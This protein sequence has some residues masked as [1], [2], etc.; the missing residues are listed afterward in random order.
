MCMIR[1]KE[2]LFLGGL[3]MFDAAFMQLLLDEGQ[4]LEVV[5]HGRWGYRL[6]VDLLDDS[7]IG[8]LL[9]LVG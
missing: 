6:V 2:W 8:W 1:V 3:E 9:N 7:L 4:L 5:D